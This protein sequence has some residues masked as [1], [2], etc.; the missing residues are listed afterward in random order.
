[1]SDAEQ[2]EYVIADGGMV[3]ATMMLVAIISTIIGCG[4][5]LLV[6]RLMGII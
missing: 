5:T 4:I 3:I 6:Q 2:Q 1:M